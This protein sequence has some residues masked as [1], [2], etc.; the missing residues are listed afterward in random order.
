M[1]LDLIERNKELRE[2]KK[3][4]TYRLN[5]GEIVDFQDVLTENGVRKTIHCSNVMF[6]VMPE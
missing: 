5:D 1:I 2:I 3:I 6:R 4:Y